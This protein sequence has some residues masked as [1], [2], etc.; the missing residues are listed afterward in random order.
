MILVACV[1]FQETQKQWFK[2]DLPFDS[3]QA[4]TD[5]RFFCLFFLP[6]VKNWIIS[7]R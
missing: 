1:V 7:S 3:G 6:K 5:V 4:F 2:E